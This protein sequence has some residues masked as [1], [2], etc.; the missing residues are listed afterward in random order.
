[1]PAFYLEKCGYVIDYVPLLDS[2]LINFE[3][4]KK[5]VTKD[6]VLVSICHVNSELGICQDIDKVGRFLTN[7]PTT[8]FHVDG[9]QAVGKID[10]YK[11][12]RMD[13]FKNCFFF[14]R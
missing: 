7:F 14:C 4:L 5:M 12:Q 1:M 10:V 9:T 13:S 6:T 3:A 11:R 2:G 8:I